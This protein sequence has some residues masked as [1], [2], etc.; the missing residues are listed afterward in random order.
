MK[1]ICLWRNQKKKCDI[2]IDD[3]RSP[4][5]TD[6]DTLTHE[7]LNMHTLTHIHM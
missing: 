2:R 4:C 1:P 5:Y 6:I 3:I 7:Q